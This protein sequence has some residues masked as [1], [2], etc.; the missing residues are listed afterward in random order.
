MELNCNLQD[1]ND[2]IVDEP[3]DLFGEIIQG[4]FHRCIINNYNHYV[5]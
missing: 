1:S 5:D 2:D 4:K 3:Q